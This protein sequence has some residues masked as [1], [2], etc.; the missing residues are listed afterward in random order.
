MTL[1][2]QVVEDARAGRPLAGLGF[3]AAGKPELS[4]QNVAELLRAAWIERLTG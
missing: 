1:L 4:E 3:G 2:G